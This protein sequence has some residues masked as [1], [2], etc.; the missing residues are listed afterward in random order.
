MIAHS[1]QSVCP[2]IEQ[3]SWRYMV[4]RP[5]R[6]EGILVTLDFVLAASPIGKSKQ[7]LFW[8][9]TN[10]GQIG[11]SKLYLAVLYRRKPPQM[12][13][14]AIFQTVSEG[15]F[16]GSKRPLL[17]E[18]LP[19]SPLILAMVTVVQPATGRIR[20]VWPIAWWYG[21]SSR[22]SRRTKKKRCSAP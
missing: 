14:P 4:G 8:S 3:S 2:G 10:S 18:H 1:S 16:S 17:V 15:V 19:S 5:I 22:A 7:V 11:I 12:R 21:W 20:G 6:G 9:R 13:P